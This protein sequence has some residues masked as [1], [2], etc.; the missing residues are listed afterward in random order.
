MQCE[1]LFTRQGPCKYY[2][3][4]IFGG[5]CIHTE[6][7]QHHSKQLQL[8]SFFQGTN[9]LSRKKKL[10]EINSSLALFPAQQCCTLKSKGPEKKK[11]KNCP[12]SPHCTAKFIALSPDPISSLAV[13]H[14]EKQAFS[15]QHCNCAWGYGQCSYMHRPRQCKQDP[16]IAIL[17]KS[18]NGGHVY[19]CT[20]PRP[21]KQC[22]GV[23]HCKCMG[24]LYK[25]MG[26]TSKCHNFNYKV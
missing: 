4:L 15:V 1:S 18:G 9:K 21:L 11:K 22:V 23:K 3:H 16:Y 10:S 14:T 20:W 25:H 17:S 12:K 24:S 6:A 5:W 8:F 13:L 7:A 19:M 26:N 2:L